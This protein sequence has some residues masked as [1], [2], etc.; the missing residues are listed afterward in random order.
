MALTPK[1]SDVFLREVDEELRRDQMRGFV[2]RWGKWIIAA[3]VLFLAAIGGYLLWENHQRGVADKQAEDF[4][5]VLTDVSAGKVK[6]GDARLDR[7]AREGTTAYQ[8]EAQLLKAGLAVEAGK[9][10]DAINIYR[11]I[12]G[13]DD[14]PQPYRD[15]A[16]VR[17]TALEYDK[18]QP[19]AVIDRLKPL[20]VKGNPWFGTAGEMVGI[21]YMRQGKT[22]L[23]SPIF[24][25]LAKDEKVPNS[26]RQR[27]NEIALSLGVGL[28]P[29]SNKGGTAA[30]KEANQ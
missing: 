25:A 2:A 22:Q 27:V 15:A 1:D 7:I 5:T 10:A 11:S 28:A 23:A 16:L 12:A 4:T 9:D 3:V 29:E 26:I 6:G 8:T 18:L 21:A 13:N 17:Q 30:A 20:A 14:L 19:Q 24:D